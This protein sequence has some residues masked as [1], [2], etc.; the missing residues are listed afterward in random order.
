MHYNG[1]ISSS[2]HPLHEQIITALTIWVMWSV[3]KSL[4]C[5]DTCVQQAS[6]LGCYYMDLSFHGPT[7]LHFLM[8]LHGPSLSTIVTGVIPDLGIWFMVTESRSK[9]KWF[10][11][12]ENSMPTYSLYGMPIHTVLSM[13]HYLTS[14]T[15][16]FKKGFRWWNMSIPYTHSSIVRTYL[17]ACLVTLTTCT[18]VRPVVKGYNHTYW[19]HT[20]IL[21]M[22]RVDDKVN[23]KG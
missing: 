3:Y 12:R 15:N 20:K 19:Q 14:D 8:L 6:I 18:M 23:D 17:Y 16:I 22:I 5:K 1:L 21:V 9:R 4:P 2:I 11:Y 7:S 10:S 13:V